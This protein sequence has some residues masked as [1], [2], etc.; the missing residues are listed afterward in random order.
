MCEVREQKRFHSQVNAGRNK[1]TV[2]LRGDVP[3]TAY[4]GAFLPLFP[5]MEIFML[6]F[7][8]S[9]HI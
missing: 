1:P 2:T 4:N 7:N 9:R 3:E 6:C 8:E 5:G